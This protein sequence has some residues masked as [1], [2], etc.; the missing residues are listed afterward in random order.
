VL[1]HSYLLPSYLFL[2]LFPKRHMWGVFHISFL[3]FSK[4]NM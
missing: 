2:G 1:H 3:G 4:L